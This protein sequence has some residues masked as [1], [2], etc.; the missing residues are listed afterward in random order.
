MSRSMRQVRISVGIGL[1]GIGSLQLAVPP[2]RLDHET[3]SRQAAGAISQAER[4]WQ[5]RPGPGRQVVDLVCLV[6]DLASFL[7]AIAAWDESHAFPILI[8]DVELSFK[9]L[10]AFRPAR[11]VRYPRRAAPI[12]A[13]QVWDAAVAAVGRS[14]TSE[15]AGA[16]LPGDAVPKRLGPTPPGVVLSSPSSP[17]LAGAVALAA[18]RFQPLIRGEIAGSFADVPSAEE[19]LSL[20]RSLE[21]R[22]AGAIPSYGTLGDD[23]D[24]LT[25]AGDWPYRYQT[26]NGPAAFDDLVGRW[27]GVPGRPRWAFTGR[28][29]GDTTASVYRAMCSLFLQPDAALLLNTYTD[30]SPPWSTYAM[31][32]AA[33][34]LQPIAPVTVREGGQASLNDWS[35]LFD[36]INRFGLVLINTH[37]TPTQF[38]LRGGPGQTDDVPPSVPAAVLMIH[39]YSAADPNDPQ[40]IAGR[41]LANGAF[42][43]FGSLFEPYLP[44]FRPPAEVARLLAAGV[45]LGAATRRVPPEPYSQPWRLV[46]LG[47]PLYQV[48]PRTDRL[49]RLERWPPVA[50]WPAAAE[51]PQPTAAAAADT[52]L[53]WVL[54]TALY[55]LQRSAQPHQPIDLP[56]ALLAIDRAELDPRLRPVYDALLID[57]LVSSER[58]GLLLEE[59][60]SIPPDGNPS[61]VRRTRES[62]LRRLKTGPGEASARGDAAR[63]TP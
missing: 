21:A 29:L 24:F 10:R 47:D 17:M 62:L 23:C 45:P 53:N 51:F 38:H 41:W 32:G 54:N 33:D 14:W 39:S 19:A 4:S 60:K 50:S 59:L 16:A 52:H 49:P 28:L 8:D 6:P 61:L 46:Y 1:I 27:D 12:P 9:F 25:L 3:G 58:A 35:R 34:A 7:E 26:V 57:T 63:R 5:G 55:Q 30:P 36:P 11:I 42:V 43:Y 37:G 40:T 2:E 48:L 15:T 22:V 20:T 44:A 56:R 31:A 13:E 18:G